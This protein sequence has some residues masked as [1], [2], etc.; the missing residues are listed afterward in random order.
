MTFLWLFAIKRVWSGG[1]ST[2]LQQIQLNHLLLHQRLRNF[3]KETSWDHS[4]FFHYFAT[5]LRPFPFH[6]CTP[7][8]TMSVSHRW[9]SNTF[10]GCLPDTWTRKTSTSPR[11][12]RGPPRR[13]RPPRAA[14]GSPPPPRLACPSRTPTRPASSTASPPWR[15]SWRR[16]PTCRGRCPTVPPWARSTLRQVDTASTFLTG[17]V[18][19]ELM[20]RSIPG[21]RRRRRRGRTAS[22]VGFLPKLNYECIILG[23]D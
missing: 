22:K 10:R 21:W 12:R 9:E 2:N 8:R 13:R 14:S 6:P 5:Q 3:N 11:R 18:L 1:N 20:C 7:L 17:S 23:Q 16:F 19:R 15:S 4:S